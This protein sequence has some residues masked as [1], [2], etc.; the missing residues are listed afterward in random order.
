MITIKYLW[1]E[2]LIDGVFKP[3]TLLYTH[4]KNL[5]IYLSIKCKCTLK[6]YIRDGRGKRLVCVCRRVRAACRATSSTRVSPP[7]C[8]SSWPTCGSGWP[9]CGP[10]TTPTATPEDGGMKSPLSRG[11]LV[12]GE[13][14]HCCFL[15]DWTRITFQPREETYGF[16]PRRPS[17]S[18][19]VT[20]FCFS[21][22]FFF[23]L[24][25]GGHS[26]LGGASVSLLLHLNSSIDMKQLFSL[27]LIRPNTSSTFLFAALVLYFLCRFFFS[28]CPISLLPYCPNADSFWQPYLTRLNGLKA[29]AASFILLLP[30]FDRWGGE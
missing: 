18:V 23:C 4:W 11:R 28:V 26:C 20:G 21:I 24:R 30:H 29:I 13:R 7:P 2:I 15:P 6:E 16:Q 22:F 14:H 12:L 5:K 10:P 27:S 9:T 8:L 25:C 17:S 1:N 3:T 19:N